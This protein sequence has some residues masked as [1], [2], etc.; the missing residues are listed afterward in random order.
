[1]TGET[2]PTPV[3]KSDRIEDVEAERNLHVHDKDDVITSTKPAYDEDE[4]EDEA[5][6]NQ[7]QT[8]KSALLPSWISS[9]KPDKRTQPWRVHEGIA[10][11]PNF[12]Q[13]SDMVLMKAAEYPGGSLAA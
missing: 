1:M 13:G 7:D 4:D 11:D 12:N 5:I 8:N 3:S 2:S 6:I 10:E 9:I